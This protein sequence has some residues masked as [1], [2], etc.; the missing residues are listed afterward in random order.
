MKEVYPMHIPQISS[1]QAKKI[2]DENPNALYVDVRSVKEFVQ[3]H[4]AGAINIPL[5]DFNEEFG[6]MMPNPDFLKVFEANVP[7]DKMLVVGCQAGGRSQKACEHLATNAYTTLHNIVGGY[8]GVPNAPGWKQLGFPVS[9]E[10]G[11]GVGYAFL[12]ERPQ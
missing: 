3:G 8:G 4:A 1:E 5:L 11:E 12:K 6:Q 10:N 7:K 9:Q 2:L